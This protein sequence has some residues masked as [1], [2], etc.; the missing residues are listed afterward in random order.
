MNEQKILNIIRERGPRGAY[1]QEIVKECERGGQRLSRQTISKILK[2]LVSEHK[3]N[4]TSN[5][6]F[7]LRDEYFDYVF[8]FPTFI[9]IF[10]ERMM[11][12]KEDL[13]NIINGEFSNAS[14]KNPAEK[15]IFQFASLIGA[16]IL[17]VLIES[18][19]LS[20]MEINP[21][22]AAELTDFLLEDMLPLR[23]IFEVFGYFFGGLPLDKPY[24]KMRGGD[25]NKI[26][27]AFKNRYP[28]IY[29]KLEKDWEFYSTSMLQS[30]P[31]YSKH[32]NCQHNWK[33]EQQFKFGKYE[34]C[35]YCGYIKK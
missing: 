10:L 29:E 7:S 12:R 33:E 3:I 28:K 5:M 19:R 30:K 26:S 9:N 11:Q 16:V 25:F 2:I 15:S 8:Y 17:Y 14:F 23:R 32:K 35:V 24:K 13:E 22:K 34:Q 18:K 4:K 20:E 31:H 6:Y 1:Q 27:K 21:K